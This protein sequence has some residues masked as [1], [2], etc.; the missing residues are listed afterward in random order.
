[1][2]ITKAAQP[3]DRRPAAGDRL[4]FIIGV[5][6]GERFAYYG[7]SSNL[8][9]YLTGSLGKSKA[10]AAE[11]VN[12]WYGVASVTPLL[13]AFIADS[14]LGRYRT[15][16]IA[17]LLYILGLSL[18]TLSAVLPSVSSPDCKN[19]V[20]T[21]KCSPSQ[22]QVI[23][24]F[25]SLYLVA[26]AQGGHKPCVQAFG[27]DQFDGKYSKEG[28]ARSSF[29]NWWYLGLVGGPEAALIFLNYIQDNLNWGLGFGIP[30]ISMAIALV[31]F[32]MGTRTYMYTFKG[33]E[34][35]PFFRIGKVFANAARNW[36]TTNS[37]ILNEMEAQGTLHPESSNQY[38]F[39]YKA[40]L[41]PVVSQGEGGVCS[42]NEI[43]DAKAVLSLLPIW[44][45]CLVYAIVFAQP[46]TFFT[47]QG[48]SELLWTEQFGQALIYLLL[49]FNCLLVF[50]SF[51][52]FPSMIAFS[53]LSQEL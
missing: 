13:G 4:F 20:K 16:L 19:G 45:S 15:I 50:P 1:M 31:V 26:V 36:Q 34:K 11:N 12:T 49:R 30:C 43:E 48:T 14:Y 38:K 47:E 51:S 10:R 25:F 23:F 21:M 35:N 42:I 39:L 37:V 29:F 3:T 24:F 2:W 52:S 28:K 32:L 22:F 7:I 18:L 33:Q 44:V 8:I 46:P 17:S 53:F 41:A 9:N 27:A 6:L 5:E 40:L